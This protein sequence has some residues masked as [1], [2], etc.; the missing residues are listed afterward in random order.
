MLVFSKANSYGISIA[1]I[2]IV[3]I[4]KVTIIAIRQQK[5]WSRALKKMYIYCD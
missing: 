3:S 5:D 4:I 1:A 2:E